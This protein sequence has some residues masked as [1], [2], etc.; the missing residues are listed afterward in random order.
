[1]SLSNHCHRFL[2]P[3]FGVLLNGRNWSTEEYRYG[4]NGLESEIG[5]ASSQDL[6]SAFFRINDSRLGRW[7][8]IDPLYSIFCFQSPYV[9]MDNNPVWYSDVSGAGAEDGNAITYTV[10]TG[11]TPESIA[12]EAGIS[13][14]ELADFNSGQSQESGSSNAGFFQ[15][16][17]SPDGSYKTYADYW[18]EGKGVE[19]SIR[20][21]DVL[22]VVDVG[23]QMDKISK[24][25]ECA[26][27]RSEESF[28]AITEK[29]SE[30]WSEAM[31]L[32]IEGTQQNIEDLIE[33]YNNLEDDRSAEG[34]ALGAFGAGK[35]G[36]VIKT[37]WGWSGTPL[38]QNLVRRVK[39]GGTL[40]NLNG[41]IPSKQ[42]AMKLLEDAGCKIKRIEGPHPSPNPHQYPHINYSTPG[43]KPGTIRI[44]G[45]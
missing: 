40:E 38:W 42:E 10:K 2:L 18:V 4:F 41:K 9:S 29:H 16:I 36:K 28:Q 8:S 15:P 22:Y 30:A 27:G 43:G 34:I 26:D 23:Q 35:L 32:H 6:W 33:A 19:W 24:E 7:F 14:W 21:G 12:K 5:V 39:E 3:P 31:N 17:R 25:S 20:P 13:I 37:K 45:L 11:D 44:E 1:M